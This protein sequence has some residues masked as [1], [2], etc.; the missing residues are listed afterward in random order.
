M[1]EW[2]YVCGVRIRIPLFAYSSEGDAHLF[3]WKFYSYACKG[4]VI[5]CFGINVFA[6]ILKAKS[7]RITRKS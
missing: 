1:A 5:M 7:S 6:G 4:L 3:R 2:L